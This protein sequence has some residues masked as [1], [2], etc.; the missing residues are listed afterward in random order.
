MTNASLHLLHR[1]AEVTA[2]SMGYKLDGPCFSTPDE[3]PGNIPGDG[4]GRGSWG[5]QSCT[6]TLHTFSSIGRNGGG[7]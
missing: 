4:P 2:I 1:A 5:Y 6:E 3:G 7:V